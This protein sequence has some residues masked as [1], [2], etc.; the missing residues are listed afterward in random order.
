[1]LVAAGA[2][3]TIIRKYG[4]HVVVQVAS[5]I[6]LGFDEKCMATVGMFT[7]DLN[8]SSPIRFAI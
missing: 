7:S 4:H 2:Y 1:M 8:V 5:K 3:G 6:E